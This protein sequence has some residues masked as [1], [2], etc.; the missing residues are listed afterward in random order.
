MGQVARWLYIPPRISMAVFAGHPLL[1]FIYCPRSLSNTFSAFTL[2]S[3]ST[4]VKL[5]H[6]QNRMPSYIVRSPTS[7]YYMYLYLLHLGHSEARFHRRWCQSVRHCRTASYT[8]SDLSIEP[9]STPPTKEERLDMN[10][11]SS[12]DSRAGSL[13][14]L[15]KIYTTNSIIVLSS[16][17][18]Q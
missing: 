11:P 2:F 17:R 5:R 8:I 1:F 12:K 18:M 9:R 13:R 7:A 10:T 3:P 15:P 14:E 6:I 4:A 16:I